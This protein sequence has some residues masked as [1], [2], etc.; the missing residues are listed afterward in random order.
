MAVVIDKLLQGKERAMKTKGLWTSWAHLALALIIGLEVLFFAF[1]VIFIIPRFQLLTRRGMIDPEL[2]Q[3]DAGLGWI[4]AF[5]NRVAA[6]GDYT[7]WWILLA[8][9]AVG[10]FEWR[11]RSENKSFIRLSFLGTVA[12]GLLVVVI[13]TTSA[14]HVTFTLAMPAFG[15]LTGPYATQQIE[16]IDRSI[17]AVEPAAAKKDW[18]TVHDNLESVSQSLDKVAKTAPV[19]AV[20]AIANDQ[21]TVADETRAIDAMRANLKDARE[22]ALQAKNAARVNDAS[23]L[24]RALQKVRQSYE[25]IREGGKALLR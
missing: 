23:G 19:V 10:L 1:T 4:P 9:V 7:T 14:L 25:P 17:A 21:K 20:L 2:L 6:I 24:E 8:A 11:V 18:K 12:A 16:N 5:L 15:R 22:A 13:I 3:K